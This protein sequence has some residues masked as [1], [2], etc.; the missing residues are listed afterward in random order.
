MK[1]LRDLK[2]LTI[3]DCIDG[4]EGCAV[5]RGSGASRGGGG[6]LKCR[7]ECGAWEFWGWGMGR[8]GRD[9]WAR[10]SDQR[11]LRCRERRE[12]LEVSYI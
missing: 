12:R 1:D 3:H 4:E 10:R 5:G 6:V 9:N 2:D 7:F 11:L 8:S